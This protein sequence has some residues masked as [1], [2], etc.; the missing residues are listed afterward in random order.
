MNAERCVALYWPLQSRTFI[1]ESNAKKITVGLAIGSMLL[2]GNYLVHARRVKN[3]QVFA[4][5]ICVPV[6]DSFN[7]IWKTLFFITDLI[8][9]TFV[10]SVGTTLLTLILVWKLH[11]ITQ[12]REAIHHAK[13]ARERSAIS[14]EASITILCVSLFELALYLPL[15][16][17]TQVHHFAFELGLGETEFVALMA[18]LAFSA[19]ILN[20]M[21]YFWNYYIYLLR[22]NCF[23]KEVIAIFKRCFPSQ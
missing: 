7:I 4:G 16:I 2:M 11:K 19:F 17:I 6:E 5:L 18:S 8:L 15:T 10:P 3:L 1:V 13:N 22:I 12:E 23:R 9:G 14:M 21:N 20:I